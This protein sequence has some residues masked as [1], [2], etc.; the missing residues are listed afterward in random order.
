MHLLF[1]QQQKN[2]YDKLKQS[3]SNVTKLTKSDPKIGTGYDI[4]CR[5]K[6]LQAVF[7]LPQ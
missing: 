5:K 4:L 2:A 1:P 3:A 6:S 7:Q